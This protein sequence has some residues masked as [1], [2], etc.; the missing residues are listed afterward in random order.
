MSIPSF[1]HVLRLTD[2]MGMMEHALGRIPRRKEGYSTDDQARA[3]WMC[4]EWLD[5]V[6]EKEAETLYGLIDTYLSFLLWVQ[7]EDGHFHNNIA[8]DRMQETEVPSDDCLGRCLWACA[9]ASVRLRDEDRRIAAQTILEKALIQVSAMRY[10]RGWAYALSALSLLIR[11]A[12]RHDLQNELD[13]L[14]Q[15]LVRL[16]RTHATTGWNWFEPVASYS[17]ALL[18]WGLLHAYEMIQD[19]DVL[20]V[21]KESLDFLIG[22]STN[23]AGQIRPVGNRGWCTRENRALWDQQPIDVMKLCLAAV[24]AYEQIGE[25]CYAAI[26][27][28]CREWFYGA[29]DAGRPMVNVKEGS[30]FDGISETGVNLNQ[31][32]E[33]TI[34]YLITEALCRKLENNKAEVEK[35]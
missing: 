27:K 34:S 31:G 28:A 10:P 4:L 25:P 13:N 8:Y 22:L 15:K 14:T 7:T 11:H 5:L 24:K 16:Y 2:E 32:A 19:K 3:L 9:L 21:T 12:D 30:C 17:N 1:K 33:A 35:A 23:E 26:A 18:P 20:A 29:N 6:G